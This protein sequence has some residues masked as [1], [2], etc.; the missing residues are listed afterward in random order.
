MCEPFPEMEREIRK[1]KSENIH[2][3][4]STLIHFFSPS[5]WQHNPKYLKKEDK[6]HFEN[7]NC[8]KLNT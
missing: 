8:F 1:K 5:N 3:I 6:I 2:K 4:E 7:L